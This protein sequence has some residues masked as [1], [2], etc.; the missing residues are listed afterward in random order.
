MTVI[1][2]GMAALPAPDSSSQDST[3]QDSSSPS[4]TRDRLLAAAVEVFVEQ[5]FE[6]ARL[7]DI[8]RA[9]GLTTGA[10]YANFRGKGDLLFDAMG[11]R[12]DAEMDGILAEARGREIRELLEV[13]GD[14]LVRPRE[15]PPLLIDAVAAARRDEEL[16]GALRDRLDERETAIAELVERAKEEGSIDPAIGTDVLTRFCVTLAMGAVVMRTL[17]ATPPDGDAW[18]QLIARLLDALAEEKSS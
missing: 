9:A 6:S 17:R 4:S 5:G 15:Q 16:A 14:M 3:S 8:A 18:H 10:I 2:P 11:V 7:Q 1:M 12:A 13:L